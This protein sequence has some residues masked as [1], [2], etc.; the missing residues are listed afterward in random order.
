MDIKSRID[1][2]RSAIGF[3]GL[4][5]S[6]IQQIAALSFGEEFSKGAVIFA[7]NDA[8]NYFHL[9]AQGLVKVSL[10][11][12]GGNCITYLLAGS[13]EPLN[14]VGPF[15]G[16]P[17]P[18]CAEA[19][20]KALVI[21]IK[22]EDFIRFSYENPS[23]LHNIIL[24]L[25]RAVDSAN[26]RVMDMMEMRV[27]KRLLK[28]LLT[29]YQKFGETLDFTGNELAELAGTTTESTLRVLARFRQTGMIRTR[30]GQIRI[31]NAM[32][33]KEVGSESMWI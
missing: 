24:I 33:L 5:D 16:A 28:V 13:G 17:R 19:L 8:C 2:F 27:E 21:R 32:Y 22:R 1:L 18:L 15:S 29:L 26:S 11:S 9:V 30:R 6:Q 14:L 4:G 7:E 23:I 20:E 10:V 12:R 3:E 31:L 25:G